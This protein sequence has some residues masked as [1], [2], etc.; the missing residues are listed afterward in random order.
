M[1]VPAFH[2]ARF[3][4]SF[5]WLSRHAYSQSL[6]AQTGRSPE[7]RATRAFPALGAQIF[8]RCADLPTKNLRGA[9]DSLYCPSRTRDWAALPDRTDHWSGYRWQAWCTRHGSVGH[10]DLAR[11]HS[12]AHHGPARRVGRTSHPAWHRRFF[13]QTGTQVRDDPCES[14]NACDH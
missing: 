7:C 13:I 1:C 14:A 10:T 3:S 5:V 12:P 8:L 4:M 6:S 9:S 11:H 2:T